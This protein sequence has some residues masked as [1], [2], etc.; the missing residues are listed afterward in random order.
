MGAFTDLADV[1]HGPGA[2]WGQVGCGC[3]P[4]CG[5][6]T[7]IMINKNSGEWGAVPEFLNIPDLVRDVHKITDAARGRYFSAFM[8]GLALLRNY[9]PFKAPAS[10]TLLDLQIGRAHV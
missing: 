9:K 1:V 7:A 3:H 2:D 10:L 4:N 8:I 5:V 6:G